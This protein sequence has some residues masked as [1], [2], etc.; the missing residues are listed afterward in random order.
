MAKSVISLPLLVLKPKKRD[1]QS[2]GDG[3]YLS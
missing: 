3:R 2:T 1:P